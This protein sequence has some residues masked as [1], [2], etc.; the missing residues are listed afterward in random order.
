MLARA[1]LLLLVVA[2]PATAQARPNIILLYSD[3][4]AAHAVS[5]YRSHLPYAFPL[6]ATPNIDRIAHEGMLFTNAFVTNSICGP[7]GAAVLTGQYGH[8]TG[9]MTN[10]DSLHSTVVTFPKLLRASGY[11]T[12]IVGKWHLKEKPAGFDHYELMPGQ[13]S[14]YNPVLVSE[15][16]SVR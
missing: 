9:V 10:A 3:D 7:G 12:A 14:Y 5:A 2:A 13:G 11:R 6:P 4:H 16:D 8:L 15:H 1:A